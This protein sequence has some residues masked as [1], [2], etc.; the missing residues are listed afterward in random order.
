MKFK[1]SSNSK[2]LKSLTPG[3]SKIS[4]LIQSGSTKKKKLFGKNRKEE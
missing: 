2:K 4:E 3:M 1:P